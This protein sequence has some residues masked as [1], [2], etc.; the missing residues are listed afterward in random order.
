[1]NNLLRVASYQLPVCSFQTGGVWKLATE[2]WQLSPDLSHRCRLVY[3][4][5]RQQGTVSGVPDIFDEVQEDLRAEAARRM[6][7]RYSGAVVA[8]VLLILAGTGGFVWWQNHQKATAD[9]VALRY[10]DA[11]R[12]ADHD[13]PGAAAALSSIAATGPE[14]YRI[15]ANL[16]LAA[17]D[18]QEGRQPQALAAWQAVAGDGS[19]PQL[20]RDL[21]T[22]S[23]VE[24]QV[25]TGNPVLLR[26]QAESLT[27]ADNPWRPMAEQVIAL[28]DL[29]SGKPAEA[30]TL[31]KRLSADPLSPPAIREMAG[32][33]LQTIDIPPATPKPPATPAAPPSQGPGTHG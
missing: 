11:A 25:D 29:R 28:L 14:G 16:R 19:A 20:L 15:L 26:Q 7:R 33:L 6:A 30:A 9:A 3:G 18:W 8:V 24:H 10:I 12:D 17:L 23:R 2:N 31:L 32:D 4:P 22:L 1:V 5:R 27:A 21:A 13:A